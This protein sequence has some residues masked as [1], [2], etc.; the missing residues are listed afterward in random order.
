MV[1]SALSLAKNLIISRMQ[2]KD[3]AQIKLHQGGHHA[4]R[5]LTT[6][7]LEP[8]FGPLPIRFGLVLNLV[9][10]KIF[11]AKIQRNFFK[12]DLEENLCSLDFFHGM[13]ALE[14]L[15]KTT[16]IFAQLAYQ[17]AWEEMFALDTDPQIA[18]IRSLALE[19]SRFHHHLNTL[20]NMFSCLNLDGMT[21]LAHYIN[22]QLAHL[23]QV[24]FRVFPAT[25][26]PDHLPSYEQL[27]ELLEELILDFRDLE[28]QANESKK[29]KNAAY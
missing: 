27:D 19:V 23:A 25:H 17:T 26:V 24:W 9:G 6:L 14:R 16:P 13:K 5:N 28:I 21:K 18:K 3:L 8:L 29:I 11:G 15:N 12:H 2:Q 20:E 1:K 7:R 10:G 4:A 22:S